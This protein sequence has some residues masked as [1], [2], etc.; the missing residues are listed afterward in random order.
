MSKYQ[1]YIITN[2][3]NEKQYVGLTRR[4]VEKRWPEYERKYVNTLP[5]G[6]IQRV[7]DRYGIE[8]FKFELL[9]NLLIEDEKYLK[10]MEKYF[11][12]E[13]DT[14]NNGYNMDKGGTDGVSFHTEE[15]KK[16]ISE[17]VSG[18]NN[19]MYG[20]KRKGLNGWKW[21]EESKQR[22]SE[23]HMGLMA[24]DKHPNWGKHLSEDTRRKISK[25]NKGNIGPNLGKPMSDLTK[26]KLSEAKMGKVYFANIYEITKPDGSV[27]EIQNL[28]EYC[29]ENKLNYPSMCQL[30]TGKVDKYKKYKVKK[31]GK[32]ERLI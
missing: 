20:N 24:G 30:S 17:K 26:K 2:I 25:A 15:T 16:R 11:V 4:G 28:K 19:P 6:D 7:I 14:F 13:Y 22:S 8:N 12:A 18:K 1:I 23:I 29:K 10:Y 9:Y 31:L 3:I 5:H 21:S 27:E 32:T